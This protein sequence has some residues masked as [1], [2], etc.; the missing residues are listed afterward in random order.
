MQ[1]KQII[2]GQDAVKKLATGANKLATAVVSTLGPRS[3]NV[4]INREYPGPEFVHDGVSVAREIRLE[5]DFEDMGATSLREAASKT[6][7]LAGDGTTTATLIANTLIQEGFKLVSSG[8]SDGVIHGQENAMVLR[9][10]LFEYSDKI[11]ALLDKAAKKVKTE[12]EREQVATISAGSA[13]IGK[14]VVQAINK[15]GNDGIVMVEKGTSFNDTVTFQEGMQFDN[16]FLSPYFV[17]NPSRNTVE[18]DKC[19][20]LLTDHTIADPMQLVPIIEKVT[21]E[22][23][24][25]VIIA[26]D[27]VGPAIPTLVLTKMRTTTQLVA[28]M[29]P[30]FADTR[31]EMLEDLAVLTGGRVM[32]RELGD[33]IKNVE[34]KDLGRARSVLVT[35]TTTTISPEHP[36]SEEIKERLAS[37]QERIDAETNDFKKGKLQERLAKLSKGLAIIE[38]GGATDAEI[39]EK[40]LRVEDAVHA[41]KAA[42]A[43]GII[44]GG[45]IALLNIAQSL[46]AVGDSASTTDQTGLL[47]EKALRAPFETLLKNSGDDLEKV[48]MLIDSLPD[49]VK[50]RGYDLINKKAGDMY[51]FGIVDP[52]KVTKLAVIHAFSVAA[53][54]LTTDT[55]ITDAKEDIQKVRA[56]Q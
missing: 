22:N 25:L 14:I 4:A 43:E 54:I 10:R 51:N 7:D 36:D 34:I 35:P 13:E 3:K 48:S 31:R 5:D 23:I 42:L 40:K 41:I 11:V 15:V 18:F 32:S 1:K 53:T 21:K 26:A 49:T 50:N 17:T 38:V 12:A 6:N 9:D 39:S 45:G 47:V 30:G 24:P 2:F 33:E 16:G 28:I 27:V 46:F 44:P 20:I 56:V 37:I 19:Y 8:I 55:L 29:A 52:V